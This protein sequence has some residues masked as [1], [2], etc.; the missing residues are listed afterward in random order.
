MRRINIIFMSL[1]VFLLSMTFGIKVEA[2]GVGDGK[3]RSCK[4]E[5]PDWLGEG[6]SDV[7]KN[8]TILIGDAA[9][10][11]FDGDLEILK[12]IAA[13]GDKN[14]G[15]GKTETPVYDWLDDRV[16]DYENITYKEGNSN[17]LEMMGM[18]VAKD[19]VSDSVGN[20]KKNGMEKKLGDFLFDTMDIK[21]GKEAAGKIIKGYDKAGNILSAVGDL[22]KLYQISVS[23]DVDKGLQFYFAL[24][25]LVIDKIDKIPAGKYATGLWKFQSNLWGFGMKT[26]EYKNFVKENSEHFYSALFGTGFTELI[27]SQEYFWED[28]IDLAWG[29]STFFRTGEEYKNMT[30]WERFMGQSKPSSR[31]NVYKPNIY[32]Y[33]DKPLNINVEFIQKELLTETIPE[34]SLGWNTYVHGDGRIT[35]QEEKYDFLFYESLASRELA[36]QEEGWIIYASTREEQLLDI[37]DEYGFNEKETVDFMEFWMEMLDEGINYIMYPQNTG[38]VNVQMPIKITPEPEEIT[39]IW[40]GFEKYQGQIVEQAEI[41]PIV[42]SGFTVVEWGGFFFE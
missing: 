41:V 35:C 30:L 6:I 3:A 12:I 22:N 21:S 38:E 11:E 8:T 37:L 32:F 17:V 13:S 33:S 23:D 7:L 5:E 18:A 9:V 39:R 14:A 19:K 24:G 1:L 31:V 20:W 25:D 16:E 4:P 28:L 36:Q 40:F 27:E 10:E 34:Y 15:D 26:Q 2:N 42:R 29:V